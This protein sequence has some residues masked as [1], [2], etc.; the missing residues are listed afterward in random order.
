MLFIWHNISEGILKPI[1]R[2]FIRFLSFI[3]YTLFFA[4]TYIKRLNNKEQFNEI[5]ID[6]F[7]R[8]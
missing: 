4:G 3:G 8:A 2:S 5:N 1:S 7:V 6:H